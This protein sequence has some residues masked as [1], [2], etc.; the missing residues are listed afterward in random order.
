M[1]CIV[2]WEVA[3]YCSQRQAIGSQQML[4]QSSLKLS[5]DFEMSQ[6]VGDLSGVAEG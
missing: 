5:K 3:L 6:T 4:H 1:E 2:T